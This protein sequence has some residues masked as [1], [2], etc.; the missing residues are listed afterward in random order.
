MPY[1]TMS[2]VG[3]CA[4]VLGAQ[5][6]G[7]QALPQTAEDIERLK[8]YTRLEA[9]AAA[10]IEE[11]GYDLEGGEFCQ[12]CKDNHDNG[13]FGIHV[14]IETAL[15]TLLGH[16]DRQVVGYKG[17]G[18][19]NGLIIP[20]E[21]KSLGPKS[22]DLFKK[23]QFEAFPE[24]EAQE[25]CYLK[26]SGDVPGLYWVM[27]RDTGE[28][29]KYLVN[30]NGELAL[31]DMPKGTTELRLQLQFDQIVDKLNQIEI[32]VQ[33]GVLPESEEND[34]CWFCRYKFVCK[35]SPV[36][37]S[38][39]I[40]VPIV[41]SAVEQ[42]KQAM[43]MEK[44]IQTM[45]DSAKVTLVQYAKKNSIDKYKCNGVSV[46]YRGQKTKKWLDEGVIRREVSEDIIRLAERESEPYDDCTIRRMKEEK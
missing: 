45:K 1:Y 42:Y 36:T 18:L 26:A 5:R 37:G 11:L 30:N 23:K 29:L 10:Q 40:T 6:L 13:R 16:K 39:D 14:E 19:P 35:R 25:C 24:Y 20:V 33:D 2:S 4:T 46:T 38:K 7:V 21:I 3:S 22:W 28:S 31:S 12:H 8:H 17:H 9:V 44:E 41:T 15:F 27:N 32:L 34:S 43:E